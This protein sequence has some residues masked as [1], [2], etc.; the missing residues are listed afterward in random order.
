MKDSSSLREFLS[1]KERDYLRWKNGALNK[2]ILENS[3]PNSWIQANK[4]PIS[5]HIKSTIDDYELLKVLGKGCM[6]K[7]KFIILLFIK[8]LIDITF[9][10][11]YV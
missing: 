2:Q 11:I 4:R 3:P 8:T 10:Y 7:V 5:Q 1:V 9:K 6:G